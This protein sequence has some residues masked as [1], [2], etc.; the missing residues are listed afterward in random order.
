MDVL[1][2]GGYN[3][4]TPNEM[5]N[6]IRNAQEVA[7]RKEAKAQGMEYPL[8]LGPAYVFKQEFAEASRKVTAPPGGSGGEAGR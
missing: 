8:N 4:F 6:K 5:L 2:L 1:D 7:L 3:N